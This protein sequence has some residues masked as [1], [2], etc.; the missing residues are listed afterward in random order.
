MVGPSADEHF[1]F[2][3]R[4]YRHDVVPLLKVGCEDGPETAYVMSLPYGEGI[5]PGAVESCVPVF[6]PSLE[7]VVVCGG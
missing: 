4:V 5:A 7:A 1:H 2:F 3:C 6:V